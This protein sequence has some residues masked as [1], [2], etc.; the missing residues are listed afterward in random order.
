MSCDSKTISLWH[1]CMSG[2][3]EEDLK[4]VINLLINRLSHFNVDPAETHE[5]ITRNGF[6]DQCFKS[7]ER[8]RCEPLRDD[9]EQHAEDLD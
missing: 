9:D 1:N 7:H 5:Y 3:V 4:E 8:C 2:K 6:C